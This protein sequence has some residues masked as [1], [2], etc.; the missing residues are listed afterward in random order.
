MINFAGS[1]KG[2][3]VTLEDLNGSPPIPKAWVK[4]AIVFPVIDRLKSEQP[5]HSR[6]DLNV[7]IINHFY[8][9]TNDRFRLV[10]SKNMITSAGYPW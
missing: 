1:R 8:D 10:W 2:A 3:T 7:I 6:L 4:P 9:A 5:R